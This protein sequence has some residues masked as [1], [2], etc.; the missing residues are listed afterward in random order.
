MEPGISQVAGTR[1]SPGTALTDP[2]LIV[3]REE[4][5]LANLNTGLVAGAVPGSFVSFST[6]ERGEGLGEAGNGIREAVWERG[7]L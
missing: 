2:D 1:P 7:L 6:Q 4:G 3:D 5:T